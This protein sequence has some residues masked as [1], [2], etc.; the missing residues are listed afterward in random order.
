MALKVETGVRQMDDSWVRTMSSHKTSLARLYKAADLGLSIQVVG[1]HHVLPIVVH[2]SC[3]LLWDANI[4]SCWVM[5]GG[6]G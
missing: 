5:L 6:E 2:C 1:A 4:R 3:L